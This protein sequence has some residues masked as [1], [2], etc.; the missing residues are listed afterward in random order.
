VGCDRVAANGDTANKIGTL[1]IAVLA[2]YFNIPFYVACPSST[3]DFS[4]PSGDY[5]PIEM[6][7]SAEVLGFNGISAAEML[8]NAYNPAFDVTPA[9]LITAFITERG[10]IK[11]PYTENLRSLFYND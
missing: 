11:P 7:D 2:L 5:I 8:V 9:G 1:G 4:M 3:I 6:R 10:I